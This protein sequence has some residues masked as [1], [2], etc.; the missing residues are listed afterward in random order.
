MAGCTVE[1]KVV[2]VTEALTD[3]CG[4]TVSGYRRF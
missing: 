1:G 4:G 2:E 3:F